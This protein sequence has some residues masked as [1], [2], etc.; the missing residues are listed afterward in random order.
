MNELESARRDLGTQDE[1]ILALKSFQIHELELIEDARE[2]K[3]NLEVSL[4]S[5][6]LLESDKN[7]VN[8]VK[9]GR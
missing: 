4:L 1:S 2:S 8:T 6:L 5:N 7:M 9:S 3:S